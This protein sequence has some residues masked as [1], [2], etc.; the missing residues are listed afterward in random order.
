MGGITLWVRAEWR[1]RWPVLVALAVL[2]AV[3]GGAATALFAGARRADTALVRFREQVAPYNLEASVQFGAE[4][5]SSAAELEAQLAAQRAAVVEIAGID[6]VESVRIESWWGISAY[7]EFDEPGTVSAFATG[8]S[9]TYGTRHTPIVLDGALPLADD[10]DAVVVGEHATDVLGWKVGDRLTFGTVSPDGLFDWFNNDATFGSRDALDGPVIEVEVVAV[11]RD[12]ADIADDRFPSILF[13]EGF[14]RAH[15]NEI[16]H[17]E[18]IAMIR[19]D[20]NRIEDVADRI[21]AILG[22]IGM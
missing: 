12:E 16:A 15:G 21:E 19:A 4:K 10:P 20:P 17:V 7:P 5:P 11:I 22:P 13:P 6:G 14:A 18:A 2:V 8:T 3:A 9:A 1:R